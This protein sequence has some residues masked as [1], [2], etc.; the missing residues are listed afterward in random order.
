MLGTER[1]IADAVAR[2]VAS[3]D[4]ATVPQEVLQA[5]L[6]H[7]SQAL[8]APLTAAQLGAVTSIAT[9]GRQVELVQGVAG[10][11]KTTVMAVLRQGFEASGCTVVGTSTSGQAARTLGRAA[12]MSESRTL[13]SLR[14]RLEHD[15]LRLTARHVLV[16]DEAGMATDRDVAF[17]LD[18]ARPAGAKVV[19]VGD[20]RQLGAVGLGG[21]LGALVERHGG[22]LGTSSPNN[23]RT[24]DEAERQA[25]L[26]LRAGDLSEAVAFYVGAERVVLAPGRADALLGELAERWGPRHPSRGG[27]RRRSPG[28]GRMWPSSTVWGA[29]SWRPRAGC[30]APSSSLREGPATRPGTE[31]S[32]WRRAW[33]GK[34]VTSERGVVRVVDL[35]HQCLTA[36]MEDGRIEHFATQEIGA[37]RLAHGYATT[38]HRSQGSTCDTAH[39]YEDGGGRELA[40][41]AMSRPE[42][43]PISTWRPTTSSRPPT[44]YCATGPPSAGGGGPSTP[45]PP[46]P[47]T[48]LG[49]LPRR[50]ALVAERDA[51]KATIP[52]DVTAALHQAR[53]R[54]DAAP[55]ASSTACAPTRAEPWTGSWAGWQHSCSPLAGSGSSTSGRRRTQVSRGGSA[56]TPAT[57]SSVTYRGS[58]RS[59]RD[60]RDCSRPGR[61]VGSPMSWAEPMST[62]VW[63][64]KRTPNAAG[65]SPNIP[66]CPV[67]WRRSTRRHGESGGKIHGARWADDRD[68]SPAP[69]RSEFHEHSRSYDRHHDYDYGSDIEPPDYDFGL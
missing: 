34:A 4:A 45:A 12:A 27:T 1:A 68:L 41:V 56:A 10:S 32:H 49:R 43:R 58:G 60:C 33:T 25:L 69:G 5:V 15:R 21:A 22:V 9:S 54:H 47:R 3:T 26:E 48:R 38:V 30:R 39:V 40:Y 35:E 42:R 64:R 20:D 44:T 28:A 13:A 46:R 36:Q 11:G 23:L 50:E 24:R 14:W 16:L 8:A 59:R 37:A 67:D 65:G 66:R 63:C 53:S 55:R 57:A 61:R 31:S 17:L 29:R 18:Q 19:M 7:M 51:L 52:E 6:E 62:W 2:G